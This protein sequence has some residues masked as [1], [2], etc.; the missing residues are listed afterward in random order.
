MKHFI[1][2]SL[3]GLALLNMPAAFLTDKNIVIL[4]VPVNFF[5]SIYQKMNDYGISPK[6][7]RITLDE[8]SQDY[9]LNWQDIAFEKQELKIGGHF[10][11]IH[12]VDDPFASFGDIENC[13][14]KHQCQLIATA[15]L[16]HNGTVKDAK[17]I[18]QIMTLNS[19]N[20]ANEE[21]HAGD[22]T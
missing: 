14:K 19:T 7:M 15:R 6:V 21:L 22:S 1:C 8:I 13:C 16:G 11:F 2:H 17:V 5:E 10:T 4:S 20:Y 3:G 9:G 12:D 18:R